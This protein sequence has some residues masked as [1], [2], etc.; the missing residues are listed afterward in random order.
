M[1]MFNQRLNSSG[2]GTNT[3]GYIEGKAVLAELDGCSWHNQVKWTPRGSNKGPMGRFPPFWQGPVQR[4]ASLLVATLLLVL[5]DEQHTSRNLGLAHNRL[6]LRE[7]Q[8]S[9]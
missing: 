8:I 9:Y 2:S 7:H 6:S 4:I 3:N 5:I 1:Q